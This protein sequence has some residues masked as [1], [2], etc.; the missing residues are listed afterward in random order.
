VPSVRKHLTYANVMSS[1]AVFGVLAGGGAV[2][3]TVGG[4]GSVTS[5][6]IRNGAVRGVD[7]KDDSLGG[8][9]ILESNLHG[10]GSAEDSDTVDGKHAAELTTSSAFAANDGARLDLP[11]DF[12]TVVS[13]DIS[14]SAP[15]RVLASASAEMLAVGTNPESGSC[16]IVI[17][18][19][20]GATFQGQ[21]DSPGTFK[22][23]V[24][25]V[26]FARELPAGDYTVE[27]EC[28]SDT[29]TIELYDASINVIGAGL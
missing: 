7:I 10:I 1:L 6:S 28:R 29:G 4:H 18:G 15:G 9:D 13:A 24:I 14:T 5:K 22:Q 16:R 25:P 27:L 20:S 2:A 21:V 8:E 12:T 26:N 17:E 11:P 23:L 19:V 3:A